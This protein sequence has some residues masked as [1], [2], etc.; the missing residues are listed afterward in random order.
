MLRTTAMAAGFLALGILLS[1][2]HMAELF[3]DDAAMAPVFYCSALALIPFA[4]LEVSSEV[5]RG[6]GKTNLY[7]VFKETGLWLVAAPVLVFLV[8]AHY[9]F[10][11]PIIAHLVAVVM[12][13]VVAIFVVQEL[14]KSNAPEQTAMPSLRD[15]L[16]LS[17]P[18]LM[19]KGLVWVALWIDILIMGVFVGGAQIGIYL[20]LNRFAAF[21]VQ[22]SYSINVYVAP[23]IAYHYQQKRMKHLRQLTRDSV[24]Y[25][26]LIVTPFVLLLGILA[27]PVLGFFGEE[28]V[29]AIVP[30]VILLL[31]NWLDT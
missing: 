24:R 10:L 1:A 31:A 30:F 9:G 12:F 7:M 5:I 26:V 8:M 11:S 28:Y 19:S 25:A 6:R 13:S 17:L 4:L 18:M 2:A 15:L 21:A 3:L 23:R 16:R 29:L 20:V 22:V 27:R 14:L